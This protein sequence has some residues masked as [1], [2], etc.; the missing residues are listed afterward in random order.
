[1]GLLPFTTGQH[2]LSASWSYVLARFNFDVQ[3]AKGLFVLGVSCGYFWH[4]VLIFF[5]WYLNYFYP[6][7]IQTQQK[8]YRAFVICISLFCLASSPNSCVIPGVLSWCI[9]GS[10][11]GHD[12]F[13]GGYL[14][15]VV[16]DDLTSI[17][18]SGLVDSS[19]QVLK[20]HTH[21]L[22]PICTGLVV[23]GDL[24]W[25]RHMHA[26]PNPELNSLEVPR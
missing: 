20:V 7:H 12:L 14:F 23:P 15:T 21:L 11:L 10:S 26:P 4:P 24:M 5:Y 9:S 8:L 19:F 22:S 3:I 16:V 2:L 18:G 25:F 17:S 13:L 1:M 6:Q